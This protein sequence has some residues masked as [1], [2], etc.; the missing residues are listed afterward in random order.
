[1]TAPSEL[2]VTDVLAYIP[3]FKPIN[4]TS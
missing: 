3:E 4:Q 2:F 1:M